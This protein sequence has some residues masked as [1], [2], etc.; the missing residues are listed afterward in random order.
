MVRFSAVLQGHFAGTVGWDAVNISFAPYLASMT[1]KE[2][3]QLAQML[4]YEFSQLAATRGGQALYTDIHIYYDV[5]PHW[6]D[7]PAVGAEGKPTGKTYGEYT[8]DAQRFAMAILEIFAEGDARGKPFI[9]PRPLLHITDHVWK[10]D[11][12]REFL[13][14]ACDVAAADGESLFC[15]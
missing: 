9:L 10:N 8:R 11:K 6:A 7:L 2:V 15:F 3:K 13:L 14:R 1:D 4:I 12:A 5:P